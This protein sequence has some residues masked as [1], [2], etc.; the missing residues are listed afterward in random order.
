MEALRDIRRMGRTR[1]RSLLRYIAKVRWG[2]L[3]S[4][5]AYGSLSV[6]VQHIARWGN[7]AE[8]NARSGVKLY[9]CTHG[10]TRLGA[11]GR[12]GANQTRLY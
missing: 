6:G 11:G 7:E 5:L 8:G 2:S 3:G 1:G 4:S 10:G 12:T 9:F